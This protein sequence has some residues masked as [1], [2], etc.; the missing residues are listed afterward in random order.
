MKKRW[1]MKIHLLMEF[2]VLKNIISVLES[3]DINSNKMILFLILD[4][5]YVNLHLCRPKKISE[6]RLK[7][8][9]ISWKNASEKIKMENRKCIMKSKRILKLLSQ[10]S[11]ESNFRFLKKSTFFFER[12]L[13]QWIACLSIGLYCGMLK[14]KFKLIGADY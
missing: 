9:K 1:I 2:I 13:K 3:I 12:I 6:N 4:L 11:C 10:K 5:K 7:N 8:Q 14:Y